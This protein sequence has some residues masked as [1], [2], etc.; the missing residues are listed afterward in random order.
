MALKIY[1]NPRCTKS[2][3]TL[4]LLQDRGLA[5]DIVEYLKNP[6]S[7]SELAKILKAL[8]GAP[9]DLVRLKDIKDK[10]ERETVAAHSAA[11]IAAMLAEN[12]ALIER[13][14]V[15]SGA[16]AAI[17]RPPEAVLHIL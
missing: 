17:G 15:M 5:P 10:A 11:S 16:K 9:S 8:G 3:E 6:P 12:P 7:K 4:K 1:H 13:P 2:R 14:I